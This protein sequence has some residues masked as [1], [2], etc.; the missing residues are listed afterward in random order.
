M[1]P[2]ATSQPP[3]PTAP[4]RIRNVVFVGPGESGKS[5]LFDHLIAACTPGHRAR[6]DHARSVGIRLAAVGLDDL[7]VNLLDTPGHPDFVGEV[8]AGLRAADAAVFVLSAADGIDEATRMLWRECALVGMPRAIAV[9]KLETQRSDFAATVATARRVF[10]DAQPLYFPLVDGDSVAGIIDLLSQKIHTGAGGTERAPDEDEAALIAEYRGD[11]IESI[12]EESEDEALLERYLGGEEIDESSLE[13]DL[14]TAISSA[15][16]FPLVPV[17]AITDVGIAQVLWLIQHAFPAPTD[18]AMP[19]VTTPEGDAFGDLECDPDG[20]LVA[21][22]VRTSTDTYIGRLS[23]VRVFSGTLRPEMPVHVS[24]HLEQFVGHDLEGHPDHDS[25]DDHVGA[26]ALPVGHETHQ[27]PHAI[28]GDLALVTKLAHAET[29]DTLSLR[30]RPALVE[31][32]TLPEPLLPVAI[33]ALSS[34]D[35]EKLST[36]LHRLVAEDVT[37]RMEHNP[38]THQLVLWAMGPSHVDELIARLRDRFHVEVEV[39][40]LKT[41]LRETFVGPCKAKGR[42]VKQS[43][44]HGQYAVCDIEV[45]PLERGAGVEFVDKV[46]G[47]AVPRKFIP[48]VEKGLRTQL[49]KG[50]LA[51]FPVEDVRITLVDG[52]AHAVDSSDMAFQTA[53]GL[54][55]RELATEANM[56]LLEP[57]DAV[58]ITVG[59]DMVGA[60]LADLRGRRGQVLGTEPAAAEGHTVVHAEVPQHELSRYPIDLRAVSHGTGTF[61]R[62]LRRYDYMPGNLAKDVLSPA[63]A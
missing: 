41:A 30:E 13:G 59:D 23:L 57:V 45:E 42:L 43:G 53:A 17:H 7:T 54:A 5:T 26:V 20:P 31:P 4:D 58:D 8:R 29:T 9:S 47:G 16:F 6:D 19:T 39:E 62:A 61:T 15:S 21:E 14:R 11:L 27:K 32:W 50:L 1:T 40:P 52:K 37:M 51:G 48:S 12:I 63:E 38:D 36:A 28:A 56:A 35:E 44:G 10:G 3:V 25:D 33:H 2:P 49:A 55:L 60:V 46:V 18:V 22:V 34:N 24:G